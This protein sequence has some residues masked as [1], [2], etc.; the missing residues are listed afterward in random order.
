MPFTKVSKQK[1]KNLNN[2]IKANAAK[3][4]KD[5]N[6]EINK[7]ELELET[8]LMEAGI[9]DKE[10]KNFNSL[11]VSAQKLLEEEKEEELLDFTSDLNSVHNG[12]LYLYLYL[13]S[14]LFLYYY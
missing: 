10:S 13:F 9:V 7:R 4:L 2:L 12:M 1:N 6:L 3:K 5:E 14:F 8:E 11:T